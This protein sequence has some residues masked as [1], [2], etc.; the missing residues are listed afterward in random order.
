MASALVCAPLLPVLAQ[1]PA[2]S[3]HAPAQSARSVLPLADGWSFQ[4]GVEGDGPVAPGFDDNGWERVS[5]PHSWNRIGEYALTRSGQHNQQG[6]GWYRRTVDSPAAAKGQRQYLDFA[7]VGKIA[8]VWVNGVHIGQHKGAF[9]RFR[10]DVTAQW[11]PGAA[12]LI[13][14]RADN[15]KPAVGSSTEDVIPLSGDFFLHGGIYREVSLVT[16]DEVGIDLL[17]HGGPGVYARTSEVTEGQA[18]VEVVTRL[19]NNGS[20]PRRLTV[21]TR[22]ADAAGAE[23]SSRSLVIPVKAG[24]TAQAVPTLNVLKPHLWNGRA[25]P[26]LYS[27]TAEVWDGKRLVDRV[28]QPLGI[29]TF[30]FDPNEGFFLNGQYLKLHG[31]SRHQDR[32]DKGWA[33]T[34][35]DHAEDM[36]MIAEMGANTI[37]QAH[38]QHADQ[39]T[40]EADR[41][42]MVVWAELPYITTPSLRGGQG[43]P[44]LW[45]NA[46]EQLREL[47]RQDY[48]HPSIMMWSIGNEVDS[49][50]GFGIKGDPPKPLALL[51]HLAKVAKE[52][53]P[54]RPTTFADCCEDLGMMQTAGEQLAGTADLIGY[55]RYFGWY[56][57]QPLKARPQL[58]AQMDRFHAKHPMLPISISEYGAGGATSQHSDN[59]TAGFLNFMGRPQPEEFESFV[60]EENWPAIRERKFIFASW[61]WNMFDFA[62]DL[63]DEGDSVDLNTKGLVTADRKIRKDAFYYYQAQWTDKPMIHLTGT[64][65][66]ERAYPTMEV[67]AY[68]N[69]PRASLT[70]NGQALGEVACEDRICRWPDVAL[71]AGPNEAVVSASTGPSDRATWTGPDAAKGLFV[72]AGDIA[73]HVVGGKRFG[74]DNFVTGGAPMLL[75]MGGFGGQRLGPPRQVQAQNPALYDYWRE[76]N[77][78]SYALPLPN[79]KWTVTIHTFE[80]RPATDPVTM[81]VTANGAVAVKAL[82]VKEA[83][84][85]ALKGISRSFPVRV[86]DGVLRLDFAGQGGRAVVAAIEVTK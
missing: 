5:V 15:S 14:V 4:Y 83:A 64:R 75:N 53:D 11:R 81:T 21:V 18:F 1:A 72:E 62:S 26:Y 78:F 54:K 45:A 3:V 77:A 73:G 57:P 24:A 79:G 59:I 42:G 10:F 56:M 19:R 6:I 16:A 23:V 85:G 67:K 30:R 27:V 74:S 55:N 12:N 20:R 37:R 22:I 69:A 7:A 17:D 66:A 9:A 82:N 60:H 29:R 63:R 44:A 34:A 58:G 35:A 25:D 46:E 48:N 2:T 50:K 76:G 13:V 8:D 68:S 28:T 36:A 65:Y 71:R 47:I 61:A 33:L 31:V 51:Q 38:Y 40:E 49:A 70:V 43:S 86:K 39:W 80:P 84:G 32:P 41:A 52:E